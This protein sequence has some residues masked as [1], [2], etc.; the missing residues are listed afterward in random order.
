M[1]T[2]ADRKILTAKPDAPETRW[3]MLETGKRDR[4]TDEEIF[5]LFDTCGQVSTYE[6]RYIGRVIRSDAERIIAAVNRPRGLEFH[7]ETATTQAR[8]ARRK[9]AGLREPIEHL[10]SVIEHLEEMA[11]KLKAAKEGA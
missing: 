8:M 9:C 10:D 7:V 3:R 11:T 6:W 1:L 4:K 5:D 2:A